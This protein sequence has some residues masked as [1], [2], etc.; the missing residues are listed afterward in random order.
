[1]HAAGLTPQRDLDV[2]LGDEHAQALRVAAKDHRRLQF[3]GLAIDAGVR[4]ARAGSD[5]ELLTAE[6]EGV[7]TTRSLAGQ[8]Q[9]D[10]LGRLCS[11][12]RGHG[13]DAE[14][15]RVE[16]EALGRARATRQGRRGRST[17]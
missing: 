17:P 16:S 4:R 9:G 13:K 8:G 6:L 15:P 12:R 10:D 14:A 2:A 1:M 7:T 11:R 5:L 3:E